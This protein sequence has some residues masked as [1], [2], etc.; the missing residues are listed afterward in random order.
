M[1][2]GRRA[3]RSRS[4]RGASLLEL[5]VALAVSTVVVLIAA[6]LLAKLA[7]GQRRQGARS[8][9]VGSDTDIALGLLERDARAAVGFP[10]RLGDYHAGRDVLLLQPAGGAVVWHAE[11]GLLWRVVVEADGS[12]RRRRVLDELLAAE[13]STTPR[14]LVTVSLRRRD[15]PPR[16]R[17]VAARNRFPAGE[18]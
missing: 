16:A 2:A 13:L 12:E 17:S 6:V 14:G 1:T 4:A 8:A 9:A 7:R 3:G 18:P 11:G 15:E 5:L 10:R